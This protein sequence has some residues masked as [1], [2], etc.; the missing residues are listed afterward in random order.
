MLNWLSILVPLI[1]EVLKII[2]GRSASPEHKAVARDGVTAVLGIA[3]EDL[4]RVRRECLGV[5]CPSDLKRD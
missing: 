2:F 3:H 1:V 5:A 4:K